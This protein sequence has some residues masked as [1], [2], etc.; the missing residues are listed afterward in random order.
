ML[1]LVCVPGVDVLRVKVAVVNVDVL[2]FV[3]VVAV[4][5]AN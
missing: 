5:V 2:S 4:A 1:D 3:S